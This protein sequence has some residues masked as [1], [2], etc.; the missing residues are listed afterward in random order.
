M[1]RA[2][3][4]VSLLALILSTAPVSAALGGTLAPKKASDIVQLNT[5]S[6]AL[7]GRLITG[8][9]WTAQNRPCRALG[10]GG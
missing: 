3:A 6:A 9:A 8:H 1:I 7:G 10:Y 4:C 2:V 5:D